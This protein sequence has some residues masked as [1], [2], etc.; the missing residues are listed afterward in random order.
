LR[1][2]ASTRD[3]LWGFPEGRDNDRTASRRRHHARWQPEPVGRPASI[4]RRCSP[5]PR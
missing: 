1:R 4:P 5:P 3:F 2:A